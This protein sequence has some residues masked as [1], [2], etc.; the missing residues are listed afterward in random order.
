MIYS[1]VAG[2]LVGYLSSDR[3]GRELCLVKLNLLGVGTRD[4]FVHFGKV[5]LYFCSFGG[6]YVL[7]VA[8]F[9]TRIKIG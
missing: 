7:F 3:H 2:R 5:C 9:L 1:R 8:R 6:F 4:I